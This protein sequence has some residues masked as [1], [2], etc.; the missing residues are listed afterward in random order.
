MESVSS[1]FLC[2]AV[3][4]PLYGGLQD[5]LFGVPGIFS[6]SQCPECRFVWLNP[7][8]IREDIPKCYTNYFTHETPQPHDDQPLSRRP[9]SACVRHCDNSSSRPTTGGRS[10]ADTR[11]PSFSRGHL[12]PP[13]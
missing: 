13:R 9:S 10:Q 1:C 5:R 2:G 6:F 4:A 11:C 3:G 7:R 8:P 12:T